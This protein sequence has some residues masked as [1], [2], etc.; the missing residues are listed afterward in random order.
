MTNKKYIFGYGSLVSKNSIQ[1]TIGRQP[2]TLHPAKLKGWVRDW[3]VILDNSTTTR[4][5]ELIPNH[6]IPKYVA[7]LNI[8]KSGKNEQATNPN[9]VLFAVNDSELWQMDEREKH[10]HRVDITDD[11]LGLV[12]GKVFAYV[13]KDEF[14]APPNDTR[15]II[16]PKSYLRL[17][18]DNFELLGKDELTYFKQSTHWPDY[19]ILPTI[20]SS[21]IIST[22]K[23]FD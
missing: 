22:N 14:I 6:E 4:R 23:I 11:V 17:V 7:A 13:G 3:R 21:E 10:Y 2:N 19:S 9:G 15:K 16:L 8:R 18:Q 20:H 1:Q 5:F 12:P